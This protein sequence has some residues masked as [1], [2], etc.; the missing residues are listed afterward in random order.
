MTPDTLNEIKRRISI[1][2]GVRLTPYKDSMGIWT[3]GVGYNLEKGDRASVCRDLAQAGCISPES[4]LD[5]HAPITQAVSDKLF[6]FTLPIY[7][8]GAR[9]SLLPGVFDALAPARQYVLVD[10]EYN[11]G[12]RGWEGFIHTRA[13]INKAQATKDLGNLDAAH[14]LFGLVADALAQSDWSR[15]VGNRALRNEAMFRTSEWCS[16]TGDGSDVL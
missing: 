9:A 15:Q 7:I 1:N 12:Q 16:P 5:S 2:E 14:A 4:V 10:L 11:L 8:A 3:V 6:S 13:L